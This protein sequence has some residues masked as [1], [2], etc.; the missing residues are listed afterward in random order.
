MISLEA[1]LD[2]SIVS[3][4]SFG[5]GKAQEV[6]V[7][8]G[9]LLGHHISRQGAKPDEERI[10][11]VLDF[12]CLRELKHVQQFL[13]CTNWLR[14]YLDPSYAHAAKVIG[15]YQKKDAKFPPNG[16]G[17]SGTEACK[18]FRVIKLMAC[19]YIL[20]QTLDIAAAIDGSRPLEQI[21]DASGIAWG[22]SHVQMNPDL[23]TLKNLDG[24]G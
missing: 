20:I 15:E 17:A 18:A 23:T 2:K 21:A 8:E 22:A 7:P 6:V 4:F 11:A 16:I 19:K 5:C 13:G 24:S 10:Q 12:A 3:G 1:F 14:M 9:K